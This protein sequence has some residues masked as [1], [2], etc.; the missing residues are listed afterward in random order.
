MDLVLIENVFDPNSLALVGFT[1]GVF[2]AND[3]SGILE[4]NF[5]IQVFDFK[6]KKQNLNIFL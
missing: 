5:E 2:T 3:A 4:G 6:S 1:T